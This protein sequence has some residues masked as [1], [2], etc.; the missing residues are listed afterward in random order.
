MQEEDK[1]SI[2]I[3]NMIE[4][5]QEHLLTRDPTTLHEAFELAGGV[6]TFAKIANQGDS[7]GSHQQD[8]QDKWWRQSAK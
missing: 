3:T 6:S 7:T 5:L 1:V 2:F 4:N 8:Y